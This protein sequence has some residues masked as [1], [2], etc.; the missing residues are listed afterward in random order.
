L[1]YKPILIRR[2][3]V[4]TDLKYVRPILIG[5]LHNSFR[6]SESQV[7][8]FYK[9]ALNPDFAV[10][11]QNLPTGP[12]QA[13]LWLFGVNPDKFSRK[14]SSAKGKFCYCKIWV[15]KVCING[16]KFSLE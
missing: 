10:G 3:G 8:A 12:N 7:N 9:Y 13:I 1:V 14:I 5:L 2:G 16:Y 6:Y 4:N 15:K 11:L